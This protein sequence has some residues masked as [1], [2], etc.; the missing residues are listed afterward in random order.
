MNMSNVIALD[1]EVDE[2]RAYEAMARMWVYGPSAAQWLCM[3][4]AQRLACIDD[5]GDDSSD[6]DAASVVQSINEAIA[7]RLIDDAERLAVGGSSE[8]HA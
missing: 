5:S 7:S 2:R 8:G 3:T 6:R 4:H 1:T